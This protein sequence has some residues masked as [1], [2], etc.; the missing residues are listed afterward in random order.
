MPH[1]RVSLMPLIAALLTLSG[2][3]EGKGGFNLGKENTADRL[4]K[5]TISVDQARQEFKR[6]HTQIA[7]DINNL[8][9]TMS[10]AIKRGTL[11][12]KNQE[13]KSYM[14]RMD[15]AAMGAEQRYTQVR[16]KLNRI[17]SDAKKLDVAA[18]IQKE[19]AAQQAE[20]ARRA[21]AQ[22]SG[23]PAAKVPPP[24]KRET[25]AELNAKYQEELKRAYAE[26][27]GGIKRVRE[28]AADVRMK[29]GERPAAPAAPGGDKDLS[30]QRYMD[31][32]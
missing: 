13:A 29:L 16:D 28:V 24:A 1:G 14:Q 3:P 7:K 8:I 18:A 22:K 32:F 23:E 4:R 17:D 12:P 15:Q 2:C 21:E 30:P 31:V 5:L 19:S 27:N 26:V 25:I 11:V 6:H 20:A 10:D 9:D